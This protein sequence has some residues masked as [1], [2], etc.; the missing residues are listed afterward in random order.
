MES[1]QE[2]SAESATTAVTSEE[3]GSGGPV[4]LR[5]QVATQMIGLALII[6]VFVLVTYQDVVRMWG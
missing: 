1:A 6:G 4:S 3:K 5:I 2:S